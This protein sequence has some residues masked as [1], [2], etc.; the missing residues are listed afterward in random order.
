MRKQLKLYFSTMT[1]ETAIKLFNDLKIRTY[2]SEEQDKWYFSIVDVVGI[3]TNQPHFQGARNYWKVLKSRLLKEG[4]GQIGCRNQG[5]SS[6]R[7]RSD[8]RIL[9]A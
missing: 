6:R 3:L 2:W 5:G 7:H 4:N 8:G 9:Q 1:K